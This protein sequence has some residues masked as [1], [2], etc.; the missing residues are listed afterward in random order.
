[1]LDEA[2]P[3]LR[4]T[5]RRRHSTDVAYTDLDDHA[6]VATVRRTGGSGAPT[7]PFRDEVTIGNTATDAWAGVVRVDLVTGL[8]DPRFFLPGFMYGRNRG[9]APLRTVHEWP[10]LRAGADDRPAAASWMTR[11]D[12]L[13][14]PVALVHG[15]GRVRGISASP[16]LF[17]SGDTLTPWSPGVVGQREQY[18]GFTCSLQGATV[19]WTLGYEH[20][21]WMFTNAALVADRAPLEGSC[22]ILGPGEEVVVE[23]HVYDYPAQHALAVSDA[24]ENVYWRYHESPRSGADPVTAVRDL[25]GAVH[26]DAWLPEE[27]QYSGFVFEDTKTGERR[28]TRIPSTAWTNGLAVAAPQLLAALRLGDQVL[29]GVREAATDLV[30][31]VVTESINLA[32]GL[33]YETLKDGHWG[34]DGWWYDG[35]GA[36]GGHSTYL[37]GQAAYYVLKAYEYERRLA[38]RHHDGWLAF[39][40]EVV[41]ALGRTRNADHEYPFLVSPNTGVPVEYDSMSGAWALAA[42]AYLAWVTGDHSG[43]DELRRSEEHYHR[44]FVERMECYGAPLDTEKAV[45]SEGVIAYAKAAR[46]L[47]AITGDPTLLRHLEDGLRYEFSFKVCFDTRLGVPPLSAVGWSSTGGTITSTANPHI[48]PMGNN[49]VDELTYLSTHAPS[50]Y[51]SSR[52]ADT[53]GW[54]LQTYNRVDGEFDYG[55]RGW[56][57]ERFCYSEGL[58]KERYPDGSLAST[59][60]A[61]MP[62]AAGC[63]VDG[64]V[65]DYWDHRR[66]TP[67]SAVHRGVVKE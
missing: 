24:V 33:P 26:Q 2:T 63:V 31:L 17:R 64:L 47:H 53:V 3:A 7:D 52:L 50:E 32:S 35:M 34:V 23:V 60:F 15:Q 14:H 6:L 67:A 39:A 13:S 38:G 44:A 54:G 11:S 56:M 61:L 22:V 46:Y 62:W 1:M 65:G 21:P 55:R 4:L 25:A 18:T 49:L 57:S 8:A 9:E 66:L 43:V 27:R 29:P 40:Q 48:H 20:A 30:E 10:R 5:A 37:A 28:Y 51:V 12:R 36:S 41:A 45:D 16:F 19:G 42:A 58:L 59:W